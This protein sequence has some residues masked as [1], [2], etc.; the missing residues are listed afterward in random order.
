M[1]KLTRREFIKACLYFFA[2][3]GLDLA[4][5]PLFAMAKDDRKPSRKDPEFEPA[6]VELHRKGVLKKRAEE[7]WEMMR[8]CELCPRR[9]GVDRLA[10]KAGFCRATS[11]LEIAAY[12]PHFGEEAPLVGR[13]GS[14][15][16]FF[17]HCNLRCVF[18]INWEISQGGEGTSQTV[19][20]LAS[21]MCELQ[22]M[23]CHNINVVTP[24]HYLPHILLAVEAASAKG[25]R[26]P[27]V[28]NTCGWERV[29]IVK[30][31]DGI[32]DIYLPD[33]K[34]SSGE[35][36]AKYS[37]DARTYPEVTRGALLEM[38]RQVGVARPSGDGIMRRGLM[39]RHLVM[40]NG[41]SGTKEVL[42]W[43]AANLPK[44]TYLNLM[45]QYRPAYKA[46]R[47]PEI[48][49]RITTQ[50]Y[51]EAVQWAKDAGLV[52]LDIQGYSLF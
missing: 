45:S 17:T 19:E 49:R 41:V 4:S 42:E 8:G 23:G 47:Y 9:C 43:I 7:L 44:D 14:G 12:H 22:E 33:F 11:E 13:G 30:R 51:R 26:L 15:T 36:A 40:P 1:R 21:M 18:C 52:N 38:H 2:L 24:T 31:L 48:S 6:Y 10:G 5:H 50:E 20:D 3:S 39:I 35:M 27:L 28:Y 29:E 32:V 25:L 34:Y 46:S 37:S 16:I